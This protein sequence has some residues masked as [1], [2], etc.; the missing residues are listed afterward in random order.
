MAMPVRHG[1]RGNHQRKRPFF[2]MLASTKAA[3][4]H[5]VSGIDHEMETAETFDGNDR[6]P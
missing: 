5:L 1:Q 3:G 4:R 6:A 2:A